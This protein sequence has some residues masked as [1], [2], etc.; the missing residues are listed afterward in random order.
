[1]VSTINWFF[2]AC[3]CACVYDEAVFRPGN[4]DG[5]GGVPRSSGG[6]REGGAGAEGAGAGPGLVLNEWGALLLCDYVMAAVD[7]MENIA[8]AECDTSIR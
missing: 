3:V 4:S 5:K 8:V 6:D 7:E 1:M 2:C